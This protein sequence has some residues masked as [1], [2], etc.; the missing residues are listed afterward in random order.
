MTTPKTFLH[1]EAGSKKSYESLKVPNHSHV[2]TVT[3]RKGHSKKS[4]TGI[5]GLERK[6]SAL[7]VLLGFDAATI[8]FFKFYSSFFVRG[9]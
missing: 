1:T 5:K 6:A 7:L 8:S 4:W 3:D 2:I 9:H